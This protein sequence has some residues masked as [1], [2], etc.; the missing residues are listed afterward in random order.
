M[1]DSSLHGGILHNGNLWIKAPDD[2][3]QLQQ[4]RPSA[5]SWQLLGAGAGCCQP[6]ATSPG[7]GATA[8]P[9]FGSPLHAASLDPSSWQSVASAQLPSSSNSTPV[10]ISSQGTACSPVMLGSW[11]LRQ[12]R[13]PFLLVVDPA[14]QQPAGQGGFAAAV[15]LEEATAACWPRQQG[16]QGVLGT[17]QLHGI[18]LATQERRQGS[19][20]A[21]ETAAAAEPP[22]DAAVLAAEELP[23]AALQGEGEGE[24]EG[25]GRIHGRRPEA[26][27][28]AAGEAAPRQQGTAARAAATSRAARHAQL[29]QQLHEGLERRA[30]QP[31]SWQL[32]Q[33]G[34]DCWAG[35]LL[36]AT[37]VDEWGSF[38]F[39]LVRLRCIGV[40]HRQRLLVRGR[41]GC[42]QGALVEALRR[43]LQQQARQHG[44]AMPWCELLGG[45]VME[46]RGD[47][48]RQLLLH[49]G[50]VS[51]GTSMGLSGM[52]KLA[53]AMAS[54][55]MPIHVT[56]RV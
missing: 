44:L 47:L 34:A 53:A 19:A 9:E 26:C 12:F 39:V 42:S 30:E 45:G 29:L 27:A 56:C 2:P 3:L 54:Q 1:E 23:A 35:S 7:T 17:Q 40:Q 33:Q 31:G 10:K 22:G 52:M 38:A 20:A 18:C 51:V 55:V 25:E 11:A 8:T 43:E 49:S 14:G 4:R 48:E 21:D 41:N 5:L 6:A 13:P 32:Q 24:G 36:P 16:Q 28:A 46:W 50:S 37:Q 15:C